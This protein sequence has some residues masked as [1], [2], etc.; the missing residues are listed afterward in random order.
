M[1][2]QLIN[3]IMFCVKLASM[4]IIWNGETLEAFNPSRGLHQGDLLSP[5]LFIVWMKVLIQKIQTTVH[6]R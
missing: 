3:F 1:E 6:K 2:T 4:S 5:Y